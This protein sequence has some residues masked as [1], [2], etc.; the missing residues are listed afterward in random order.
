M[1]TSFPF[2][3]HAADPFVNRHEADPFIKPF[4]VHSSQP[5][6]SSIARPSAHSRSSFALRA[7]RI[8]LPVNALHPHRSSTSTP[9]PATIH[10]SL[11]SIGTQPILHGLSV[12]RHHDLLRHDIA[13]RFF[14][15]RHCH[16]G[17]NFYM[18]LDD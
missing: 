14:F 7:Q 12:T 5:T 4:G 15:P 9:S 16:S 1:F 10:R 6:A 11:P 18:M 2:H 8:D 17:D 13:C 3:R